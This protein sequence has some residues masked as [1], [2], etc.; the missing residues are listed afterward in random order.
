MTAQ[1]TGSR[2]VRETGQKM[3]EAREMSP[4]FKI[5][6]RGH[7]VWFLFVGIIASLVDIGLLFCFCEFMGFGYLTA[8]TLSYCTGLLV[9]YSLN[10]ILTFHDRSRNYLAQFTAFAIVSVSGLLVN[11]TIIWLLV[12]YAAFHY[13]IAKIVAT[14]GAFFWN[15]Y[16]QNRFTFR[17]G[18]V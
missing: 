4:L 12:E 8:A 18:V 5:L 13:L 11:I 16:G 15:Y 2:P 7:L 10:K 9:S 6:F 1:G 14:V 17:E 3:Q